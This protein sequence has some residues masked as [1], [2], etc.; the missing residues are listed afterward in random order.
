MPT[1]TE[2]YTAGL[3]ALLAT[4]ISVGIFQGPLY[5]QEGPSLTRSE[6][7]ERS[8]ARFQA[9]DA[10]KDGKVTEKEF[11][12]AMEAAMAARGD[13]GGPRRGGGGGRGMGMGMFDRMDTN[14]DGVVSLQEARNAAEAMFDRLDANK[15]GV[16]SPEERAAM[17][18]FG[19][20][21]GDAPPPPPP[22]K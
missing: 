7:I 20:P 18:G 11:T 1:F 12:A 10:N 3:A 22:S 13:G 21:R 5:A 14:E 19:G 9:M 2:R 16:V 17:R 6:S 8:V 15:D 4:T